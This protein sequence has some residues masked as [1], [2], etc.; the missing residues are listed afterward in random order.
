[1][2]G[3]KIFMRIAYIVPYIP[4]QIKTRPYN[5]IS[6]LTVLGHEVDVF[7]VGSNKTD[8]LDAQTLQSKCRKVY[9]YHQPIWRSLVNSLLAMPSSRPLQSVYS[10]QPE[11]ASHLISLFGNKNHPPV[12]DVVH[13]E[14]LRGSRYGVLIKSKFPDLPL[15]WDSVDCISHLFEQAVSRSSTLFGKMIMRV[16]LGRTRNAEGYL[17]SC[18]DHVLVT[19][20]LDR[21][22]LLGLAPVER[23]PAPISVLSNGVDLDY[24]RPNQDVQREPET[25]VFTGKMSYHANV[26]MVKY[27]VNEVMPR[28]WEQRPATRLVVVGKDPPADIKNLASNPL[29]TITGTVN[30][31]R[32]FLWRA[33]VAVAPLVYGAG[34]QNKILEAMATGTPVVTTSKAVSA[35][36]TVPGKD[37][38]VADTPDDFSSEVLRLMENQGFQQAIATNGLRYVQDYHNWVKVVNQLLERYGETISMCRSRLS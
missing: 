35:L 1:M 4:N 16:E 10:W 21:D 13:V 12:Y 7:T 3:L 37:I 20:A 28:I 17:I 25:I 32:P 36:Q 23:A 2:S 8:L 9:Y 27:L 19:S 18:F 33:A 15:V 5:L 26:S 34:I 14:H 11:L 22:A 6:C 38:I 30:D 31:I 24:F 29:I